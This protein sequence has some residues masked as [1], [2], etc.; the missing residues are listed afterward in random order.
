[1][2]KLFYL[3][4]AILSAALILNSCSYNYKSNS[5]NEFEVVA[6]TLSVKVVPKI[7]GV[8]SDYE[9]LFTE[10]E[11]K[12]LTE[13]CNGFKNTNATPV[14]IFTSGNIGDFNNFTEYADAVSTKW[15]GCEENQGLLFVISNS[16]GEVRLI[17]CSVTE[18]R[19]TDDDFNYVVNDILYGAFRN[20]KFYDGIIESLDYLNEKIKK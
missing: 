19:I 18:S 1:M 5:D 20:N 12:G 2:K 8:V 10:G 16:L 14:A 4:F 17:S 11:I 15:N 6:D 13:K 9:E 3:I 7:K